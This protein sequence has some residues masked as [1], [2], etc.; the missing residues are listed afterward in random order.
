MKKINLT[1]RSLMVVLLLAIVRYQVD[2]QSCT[3]PDYIPVFAQELNLVNLTEFDSFA[4]PDE[5]SRYFYRPQCGVSQAQFRYSTTKGSLKLQMYL[6]VYRQ[7]YDCMGNLVGTKTQIMTTP[8]IEY[9][10]G[11]GEIFAYF[12]LVI[13][14]GAYYQV[15]AKRRSKFI[16]WG[17]W[18]T[19][20][21]SNNVRFIEGIDQPT[22]DG[23]FVDM[24]SSRSATSTGTGWT[25]D[26]AQLDVNDPVL[27]DANA[28]SCESIWSYEISEFDLDN[29]VSSSTYSSP[30][31]SGQ[32]NTINLTGSYGPGFQRGKLYLLKLVVGTG[33]HPEYR[34]FEIKDAAIDASLDHTTTVIESVGILG[35]GIKFYTL[36]ERCQ[37][38]SLLLNTSGT[39][40]ANQYRISV[41]EVNASYT[42][43]GLLASTGWQVGAPPTSISLNSLFGG[44][45]LGQRYKLT[46]E[47]GDPLQTRVLYFRYKQCKVYPEDPVELGR[48]KQAEEEEL[49]M[50]TYPNPTSGQLT[51]EL[52]QETEE[53]V[54][55]RV[56][57][58][59]GKIVYA[60]E[61]Y[62]MRQVSIDLSGN[63]PGVYL[64]ELRAAETKSV[65]RVILR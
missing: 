49:E 54:S 11:G 42:T 26:I 48:S 27:F 58:L 15:V 23:Q 62:G 2:A 41:Q 39:Q 35:G 20:A 56:V 31:L 14:P 40:S 32:A 21:Y 36:H 1:M 7:S 60:T 3:V 29:W 17:A 10:S 24:L 46:F 63:P 65:H 52:K 61:Q 51:I 53:S 12:D 30:W 34:W 57:D 16:V 47:V 6:E 9:G 55:L 59:M 45:A 44:F 13:E 38:N 37:Y 64:I 25:I 8:T 4:R 43:T 22:P 28:S 33:Y 18:N 5:S 19:D 50:I